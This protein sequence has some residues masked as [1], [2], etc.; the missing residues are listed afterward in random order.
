MENKTENKKKQRRGGE[1][2][3]SNEEE[4]TEKIN[5]FVRAGME[6][7]KDDDP[8]RTNQ[9]VRGERDDARWI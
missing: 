9:S 4:E 5:D 8:T 7:S 3:K 6:R 1:T 2:G